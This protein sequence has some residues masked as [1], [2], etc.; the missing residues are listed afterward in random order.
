[1]TSGRPSTMSPSAWSTSRRPAATPTRPVHRRSVPSKYRGGQCLGTFQ[2][3]VNPGRPDPAHHHLHHRHHRRDGDPGTAD[4]AGAATLLEFLAMPSSSGTT[5]ASMSPSSTL[6]SRRSTLPNPAMPG[7]RPS[8]GPRRGAR[9]PARRPR[10]PASARSQAEPP[11]PSRRGPGDVPICCT[12]C[13]NGRPRSACSASTT[14]SCCPRS[15]A[16]R[17]SP[18]S[19]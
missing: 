18:S 19:S 15:A 17:R 8:P 13:W 4:R 11:A 10:P 7:A 16:T 14:C 12:C 9:L 1:M 6:P 2:T 5:C 3:L